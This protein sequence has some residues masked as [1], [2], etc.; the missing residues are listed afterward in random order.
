M[1]IKS[2]TYPQLTEPAKSTRLYL[3]VFIYFTVSHCALRNAC[4]QTTTAW[5][6]CPRSVSVCGCCLPLLLSALFSQCRTAS[7]L[8]SFKDPTGGS[9]FGFWKEVKMNRVQD[10]LL[11]VSAALR[12]SI[13]GLNTVEYCFRRST[14]HFD[15]ALRLCSYVFVVA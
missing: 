8:H 2:N 11:T 10:F 9:T 14:K 6:C 13:T 4:K 3:T 15:Y 5:V 12:V 1:F 7:Y